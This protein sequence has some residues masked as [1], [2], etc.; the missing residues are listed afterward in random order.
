MMVSAKSSYVLGIACND[1]IWGSRVRMLVK[2]WLT[3]A[4]SLFAQ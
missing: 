2:L 1:T 4:F 3:Q